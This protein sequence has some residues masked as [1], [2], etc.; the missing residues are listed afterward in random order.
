MNKNHEKF[1]D[2][3]YAIA[4]KGTCL[5]RN[6]GCILTNEDGVFLSSGYT[7]APEPCKK[8]NR[9]ECMSGQNYDFCPSVHAEQAALIG[10]R[11][12]VGLTAYLACVD[13]R[14][15]NEVKNPKPCPTCTKLL[16]HAG[17]TKVITRT[18]VIE[19]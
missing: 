9:E 4:Q 1:L 16:R 6:Y 17:V 2:V 5:K 18:E 19:L 3:A 13:A 11:L 8:C 10:I 15:G 12:P 7:I 14:T